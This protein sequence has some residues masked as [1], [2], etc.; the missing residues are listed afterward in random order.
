MMPPTNDHDP[1]DELLR[2]VAGAPESS[3]GEE[4]RIEQRIRVALSAPVKSNRPRGRLIWTAAAVVLVIGVLAVL[5]VGKANPVQASIEQI[6]RLVEEIEPTSITDT[7]FVYVQST[8]QALGTVPRDGLGDVPYDKDNLVY[9]TH[10]IRETWFGNEE[11][12]QIRTTNLQPT[13][14][15]EDDRTA[16]YA[17]GLDQ[18]DQIGETVTTTVNQPREIWSADIEQ[19]DDEIRSQMITN[20]GL[21]ATVEYLDVAFD[22]LGVSSADPQTR[23]NTLRLIGRLPDL[24][25]KRQ[26][27]GLTTFD[28]SY[29]SSGVKTILIFSI[30]PLGYLRDQQTI[31]AS[32]DTVT[33][34]PAGTAIYHAQM[35]APVIATSLD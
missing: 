12:V 31:L 13:F 21:P 34:V 7:Q 24:T 4:S 33:G 2:H 32:E 35:S 28:I 5:Q 23:A 3:Q 19:L 9:L 20:R 25:L 22:I 14:F 26:G 11:T 10:S 15:N 27:S 30:D 17:A 8:I 1:I 18:I 16:Y 6:A 29:M